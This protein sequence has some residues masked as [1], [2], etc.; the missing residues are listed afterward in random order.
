M[1]CVLRFAR[2]QLLDVPTQQRMTALA[3]L[4]LPLKGLKPG[5]QAQAVYNTRQQGH[6]K[7]T[8]GGP[9]QWVETHLA[10]ILTNSCALVQTQ[11]AVTRATVGK[12]AVPRV[13][14]RAHRAPGRLLLLGRVEPQG[15]V[16]R[17]SSSRRTC[18]S[19]CRSTSCSATLRR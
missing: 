19:W 3:C 9:D 15:P 6:H 11:A 14:R 8:P 12:T 5:E 17:R 10:E 1:L 2:R 16:R 4:D 7:L 18:P 13:I